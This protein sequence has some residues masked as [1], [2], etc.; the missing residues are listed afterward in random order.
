MSL[1]KVR[2]LEELARDKDLVSM[3]VHAFFLLSSVLLQNRTRPTLSSYYDVFAIAPFIMSIM[4]VVI[5]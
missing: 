1:E 3:P 2:E 4:T 5:S